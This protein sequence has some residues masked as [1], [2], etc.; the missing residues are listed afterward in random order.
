MNITTAA[1]DLAKN[2]FQI[3][4]SD[5]SSRM[6][7]QRR[8]SR[9]QFERFFV[10][11]KVDRVVMEACGTAHHFA[12]QLSAQGIEVVLLPAQYI[13]AYV[14]RNKTDAAD[15]AAILEASRSPDI[16]PVQIK[17]V[18][19]QALQALHRARSLRVGTRTVRIN[20]LRGFCREMGLHIP[21][22]ATTG[23]QAMAGAIADDQSALPA[24]LR[25]IPRKP[26]R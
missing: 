15:A 14:R 17:S 26:G 6:I 22:G 21:V 25:P 7:E 1:V 8:L 13:R 20:A 9:A 12:R 5:S 24:L 4:M 3:A 19:Q 10:N 2:V 16:R 11:R 23:L 18:E